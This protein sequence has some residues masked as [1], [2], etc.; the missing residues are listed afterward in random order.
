M[1]RVVYSRRARQ[2]IED[3]WFQ[4]ASSNGASVADGI[5][6]R[7]ESRAVSLAAHPLLGPARP[8]I[9]ENARSLLVERWLLL[10]RV[11]GGD[12]QIIRIVDGARDL[13]K[14]RAE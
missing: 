9:A 11:A 7:I 8:E 13:G 5:L 12:V 10:Y 2:D 1:A 6:D 14:I 3:I 4:V